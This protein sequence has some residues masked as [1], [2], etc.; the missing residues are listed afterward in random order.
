MDCRKP[1]RILTLD[2]GGLQASSTLLIL[3]KLLERV[4]RE[5]GGHRKPKPCDIFDTI[6]G[7][8]A[9]G[10][11]AILLGRFRMDVP[12]CLSEWNRI[13]QSIEPRS[14]VEELRLKLLQHCHYNPD[15]L[16]E[17][18]DNLNK[19]YGTGYYLLEFDP[20]GARTRHVFVAALKADRKGY[21]LFRTYEIPKLAKFPDKLLEGPQNS[22]AFQM[23]SAFVA[24]GAA[25]YLRPPW[26]EQM[27][28]SGETISSDNKV[29]TPH[30]ITELALDEMWG[31]YGTDVPISAIVNIGPQDNKP[32][33]LLT[34][35]RPDENKQRSE[36]SEPAKENKD[37]LKAAQ[38]PT[39]GSIKHRG[40]DVKLG[41][42][43]DNIKIDI[44]EKL[45]N[46]YPDGSLLYY[47]LTPAKAP[48]S[49]PQDGSS[50]SGTTFDATIDYLSQPR[51]EAIFDEIV[52][53]MTA[54]SS[55]N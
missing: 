9:G 22:S 51:V 49:T 32:E 53:R 25:R 35:F 47:R 14:K 7:I 55:T 52:R 3:D 45:N 36:S 19:E 40:I 28:H 50:K 44:K 6:T 43:E 11:L 29:P 37:K 1:L 10:W 26:K 41:R 42:L 54:A 38:V 20:E 23:S 21:N 34:G 17:Q 18:I 8:G 33:Q 48:Q 5:N 46:I 30:N 24:T 12:S 4:A 16:V 15:R 39:F 2:G 27:A 31:I 13:M